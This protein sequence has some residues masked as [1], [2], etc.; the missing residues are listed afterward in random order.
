[1][2]QAKEE[3]EEE[4][5][6]CGWRGSRRRLRRV[7]RSSEDVDGSPEERLAMGALPRSCGSDQERMLA[8][9][10]VLMSHGECS[11]R[12][13]TTMGG[14]HGSGLGDGARLRG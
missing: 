4:R 7:R 14:G 1:M 10:A 6:S 5:C 8:M 2:E 3:V 11:G 9:D 13:C 12:G